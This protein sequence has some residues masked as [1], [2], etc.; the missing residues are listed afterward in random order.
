MSPTPIDF[1]SLSPH[2]TSTRLSCQKCSGQGGDYVTNACRTCAGTG[3]YRFVGSCSR[4]YGGCDG[5]GKQIGS[6]DDCRRCNGTGTFTKD[7]PC[8][9]CEGQAKF[10]TLKSLCQSCEG[11]GSYAL[12][13]AIVR[14]AT[15]ADT[16]LLVRVL[17]ECHRGNDL[18]RI[19]FGL[20]LFTEIV[21][22]Y[23]DLGSDQGKQQSLFH[24]N[25]R[26]E[27]KAINAELKVKKL[28]LDQKIAREKEAQERRLTEKQAALDSRLADK[29][30]ALLE[31][32][33]TSIESAQSARIVHEQFVNNMK[34]MGIDPDAMY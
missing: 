12:T 25:L 18:S 20:S 15:P 19:E 2:S 11:R 27:V 14:F 17:R 8:R 1:S 31:E 4:E 30:K 34:S 3:V 32:R 13:D 7:Y 6:L 26:T 16:S 29:Q 33:F 24:R 22:A 21:Q 28:E 5:T 23:D 9:S 10:R